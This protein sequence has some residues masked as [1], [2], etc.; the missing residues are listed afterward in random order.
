[1]RI[2]GYDEETEEYSEDVAVL[3][4]AIADLTK[5][6]SNNYRGVSLFEE[7]DPD[8]YRST[9]DILSDISDIWDEISDKNQADLLQTLFGKYQ[10]EIGADILKNFDQ[11]RSAIETMTNSAGSAE[12]EME[13]ITQSLDYK[14]NA[15]GQTWVGVAQNLFTKGDLSGF[16]DLLTMFSAGVEK[17]TDALGLFGT[18]GVAGMVASIVKLRNSMGRPKETGFI[19][20]VPMYALA[21][22]RNELAA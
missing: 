3:T 12:A 17:A 22:T 15:L 19:M 16:I 4:G 13:K 8:T 5:A 21:V 10:A 11:A 1:M 2:R 20:I 18:I 7:G 14:L 6:K 9:Y